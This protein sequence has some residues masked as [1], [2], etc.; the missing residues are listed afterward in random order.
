MISIISFTH[1]YLLSILRNRLLHP[2][3][4]TLLVI[5][6]AITCGCTGEMSDASPSQAEIETP[7]ALHFSGSCMTTKGSVLEIFSFENDLLC[8]LDSYMRLEDFKGETAHISSTGGEKII[9]ICA[10]GHRT[11]NDWSMISSYSSLEK[12]TCELENEDISHVTKTGTCIL[13]AGCSSE[14]IDL[15][16]VCCEVRLASINCD[17]SGTPYSKAVL[18][19]VKVYLTNVSASCP[20]LENRKTPPT[21]IINTGM[22]NEYDLKKFKNP[23]IIVQEVTDRL[24]RRTIYPGSRLLC[25]PN[26]S[27]TR[28][29]IEGRIGQ[30]TFYWP[31]TLNNGNGIT[32]N[33]SYTYNIRI[34]RKG[35]SDPDIPIE[36]EDAIINMIIKPW[37]EIDEYGV[38]F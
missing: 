31:I 19:D 16:P 7:T 23:D 27:D 18:R 3:L 11:R 1:H 34:R 21:R 28:I 35:V 15:K 14:S 32:R 36:P 20:M 25:Y 9:F 33:C 30:D 10:E 12:I 24:D 26:T 4:G 2:F 37:K 8:R 29:V 6:L 38:S 17:F 22:L 5:V 13:T